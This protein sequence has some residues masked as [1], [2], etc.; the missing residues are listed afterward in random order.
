MDPYSPSDTPLPTTRST[1]TGAGGPTPLPYGPCHLHVSARRA[2]RASG[3]V[4]V[5]AIL[6]APAWPPWRWYGAAPSGSAAIRTRRAVVGLNPLLLLWGV[7][8]AHNDFLLCWPDRAVALSSTGAMRCRGG[9]HREHAIKASPGLRCLPP[10]GRAR[11]PGARSTGALLGEQGPR[12]GGRVRA[13]RAAHARRDPRQ[14]DMVASTASTNQLGD[15]SGSAASRT[16][17][18]GRAGGAA[19]HPRPDARGH[20]ARRLPWSR[21]RLGH[22]GP[23]A[24]SAG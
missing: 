8:G 12:P 11:K 14:Q 2:G 23:V 4:V 21:R 24:T 19:G 20:L 22:G 13:R 17:S 15:C 7:G 16:G 9:R 3:A 1:A 5:K 6:G 10:R 18:A